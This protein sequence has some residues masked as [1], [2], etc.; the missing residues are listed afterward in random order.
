MPSVEA[1]LR[2]AAIGGDLLRP[3]A[4]RNARIARVDIHDDFAAAASAWDGLAAGGALATPFSRRAWVELWHEHVGRRKGLK[5]LI[6][7]ACNEHG[8]PLALLPFACR[9][10]MLTI[11]RYFGASHSQLNMGVWRRDFAAAAGAQDVH[12]LFARI[13]EQAGIDLFVLL[14]QPTRWDER[15]SPLALLPHQP[16][17]D[18]VLRLDFMGKTGDDVIRSKLKP[19]LRGLLKSKEKKLQRLDG[20]RYFRAVTGPEVDRLLAAFFAQKAEHLKAQGVANVFA[21]PGVESFLR[22]AC[23]RDLASGDPVIELHALEGGGEILA[24]MGGTAN[25]QRFSAMFN[26]YTLTEHARWS[27]GLILISHIVRHCADRG[28]QSYDLGAGYAAYKHHFCKQSE[29]LFDS[30]LAFSE[31][32]HVAAAAYR[33]AYALKRW[34]KSSRPLWSI[35]LAVRRVRTYLA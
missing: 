20:Y 15:P 31:R 7:V 8:E 3:A 5:P 35:I 34:I 19:A 10:G 33:G 22:A 25:A 9:P 6:A 27:P 12:A 13:A 4:A 32:G 11:A 23:H 1:L 14:A 26:S 21:E 2:P 28:L 29:P 18:Q 30:F 24:V 17:S 16:S